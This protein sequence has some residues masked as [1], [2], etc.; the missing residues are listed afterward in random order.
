MSYRH[1]P[2]ARSLL[3]AF[4]QS[5]FL[6][7][8]PFGGVPQSKFLQPISFEG[9]S[10]SNFLQ[11]ISF[12]GVSPSKF[13]QPIPF[14]GVSPSKFLQPISFGGVSPS[15][16]LQPISFGGISLSN[17]HRWQVVGENYSKKRL[18]GSLV[19]PCRSTFCPTDLLGR[20]CFATIRST[21]FRR[22]SPTPWSR[23]SA[24]CIWLSRGETRP[25][26]SGNRAHR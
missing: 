25:F 16:F 12:E 21:V 8:I 23:S 11:P 26:S 5:K 4:P 2:P 15:N 19:G 22:R 18:R 1:I 24:S 20:R 13:L 10:P 17:F 9:V 3:E 14:G 6:Q 7:P